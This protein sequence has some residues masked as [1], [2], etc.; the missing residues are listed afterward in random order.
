MTLI[1]IRG[2]TQSKIL[3]SLAD[4]ERHAHLRING[5]PRIMDTK[6]AD[7]YAQSIISAKLRSKSKIAVLVSVEEDVTRSIMQ[8]KKIHPPA[9]LIVISHE[10]KEWEDLKKIFRTLPPLKGYYSAKK[11]I[12]GK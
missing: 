4:I 7:E 12:N 11:A 6:M 5:S 2:Q 1:L 3:N 9:H 8:V 10:Y